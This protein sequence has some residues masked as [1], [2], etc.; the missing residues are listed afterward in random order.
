MYF[1]NK[2]SFL[3]INNDGINYNGIF[4]KITRVYLFEKTKGKIETE[5]FIIKWSSGNG[6]VY[7]KLG[8]ISLLEI[9][10]RQE[11]MNTMVESE[12]KTEK[13]Y[14]ITKDVFVYFKSNRDTFYIKYNGVENPVVNKYKNGKYNV[15]IDSIGNKLELCDSLPCKFNN[16]FI[17][18]I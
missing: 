14:Y 16:L 17:S 12:E 5:S 7:D 15:Y 8:S 6:Y 10:T 9:L 13:A 3:D 18:K 11:S 1:S 2:N 4:E